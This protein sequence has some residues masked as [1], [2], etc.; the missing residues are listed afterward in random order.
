MNCTKLNFGKHN[1][2]TLTQV[3]FQDPDWF[4]WSM[5]NGVFEKRRQYWDQADEVYTKTCNIRIPDEGEGHG[6]KEIRISLY[7]PTGRFYFFDVIN[8]GEPLYDHECSTRLLDR[9]DL[10]FPRQICEYDKEGCRLMIKSL[11]LWVFGDQNIVFRK[12]LVESFFN[13]DDNFV[14]SWF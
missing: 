3:V 7:P 2:K 4:F 8:K 9:I 14:E 10:S 12:S 13:E 5:D 1:G 11:K 6:S